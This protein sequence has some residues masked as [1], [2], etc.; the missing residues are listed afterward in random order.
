MNNTT[1]SPGHSVQ[2][3]LLHSAQA[4]MLAKGYDATTVDEVCDSAVVAKGSFYY[5]FK[6]KEL[7]G[8]AVLEHY[9]EG[10]M[11]ALLDDAP[12]DEADPARLPL[13]FLDHAASKAH[14][15]WSRGC[16]LGSFASAV[17]ETSPAMQAKMAELFSRMAST[18]GGLLRAARWAA[19]APPPEQLAQLFLATVEGA[20]VLAK[21]HQDP[22]CI[23][24]AVRGYR[25][26]IA[27]ILKP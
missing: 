7:L 13:R 4:L 22:G 17:A 14:L 19:D 8:V 5:H 2:E 15:I 1:S 18:I 24:Q 27:R 9:Y 16:L 3:R 6:S 10:S 23:A 26:Y 11:R 20:I 12:L 21:A 25:D